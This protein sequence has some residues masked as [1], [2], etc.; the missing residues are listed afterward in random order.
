MIQKL[1][2]NPI[3][4]KT[5]LAT[6]FCLAA[7]AFAVY[8]LRHIRRSIA[9]E[10]QS[11]N[12]AQGSAAFNLAAY[13]GL[14]RQVRDKEQELQRLR[15][16]YK[17][18][19]G[20]AGSVSE[21]VLSNLSCGVVFFDRAGV[22]RQVNRAAKSLLGYASPFAFHIRD[23]FRGVIRIQWPQTGEEANA[24]AP[25]VNALQE[26]LRTAAPCP[27]MKLDY[28][29]PGGQ[30]RVLGLNAS[31]VQNKE[32]E[33]LG[34]SCLLDDLTDI[35]EISQELHRTEGLASLGEIAAGVV[36]DFRKSLGTIRSHAE[37]LAQEESDPAARRYYT[38]KIVAEL[39]S[40]S[41]I[42]DEYLEFASSTKN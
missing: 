22:V 36:H 8:L 30:K 42:V 26:T 4:L 35:T 23:L 3:A 14:L 29:T 19:A 37:A 27:K 2:H 16:Q 39:D 41:R 28:R 21:A 18:E 7:F 33:I 1:L 25:L 12:V 20:A 32:G 6:L 40:L 17:L 5:A 15:D 9:A 10:G 13:D 11:L 38:E 24:P 31:A 34:V